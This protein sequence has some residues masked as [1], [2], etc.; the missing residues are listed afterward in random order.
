MQLISIGKIVAAHGVKGL[1]KI[2]PYGGD[3]SLLKGEIFTKDKTPLEITLKNS[4]GKFILASIKNITDRDQAE[5]ISGTE[6]FITQENLPELKKKN[7][8][9]VSD[10]MGL[11]AVEDGKTIGKVTAI[12]NFGAGDLIEIKPKSGDSFYIP[13]Q[14]DIVQVKLNEGLI[15]LTG[16]ERFILS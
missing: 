14:D 9:Y 3:I 1:V 11:Q 15:E 16:H 5:E 8:Y 13:F 7:Q 4:A 6:I 10:L 12:D 2:L